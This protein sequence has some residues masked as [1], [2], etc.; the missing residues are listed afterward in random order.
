MFVVLYLQKV[1]SKY[2]GIGKTRG[3]RKRIES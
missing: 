2:P 1:S 3:K